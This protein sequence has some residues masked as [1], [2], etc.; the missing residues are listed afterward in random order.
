MLCLRLS[1][2]LVRFTLTLGM[3]SNLWFRLCS[4][5]R[6]DRWSVQVVFFHVWAAAKFFAEEGRITRFSTGS[7][8][9]TVECSFTIKCQ[10]FLLCRR[11]HVVACNSCEG[12]QQ[13]KSGSSPKPFPTVEA[14]GRI[15]ALLV[16]RHCRNNRDNDYVAAWQVSLCSSQAVVA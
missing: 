11:C 7:T 6:G 5:Q 15:H 14:T 9:G 13:N 8:V 3:Q 4:R 12:A 1:P 10:Y 16:T 2:C